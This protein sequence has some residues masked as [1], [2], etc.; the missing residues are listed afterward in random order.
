MNG[1]ELTF[2]RPISQL[3]TDRWIQNMEDHMKNNTIAGKDMAQHVLQYFEKSVATW[4][5]MY[6][7]INGWQ[8][9]TTW[10]EFKLTLLKSRLVSHK[11]KPYGNVMR[12]S[13][14]QAL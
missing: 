9:A 4:L 3:E 7:A 5:S 6:Q 12:K 14:M 11:M 8:G 10:E 13:C 2:P 1:D